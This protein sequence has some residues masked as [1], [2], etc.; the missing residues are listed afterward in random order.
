MPRHPMNERQIHGL[1][2]KIVPGQVQRRRPQQ[3][4]SR[5][6]PAFE[7]RGRATVETRQHLCVGRRHH[8]AIAVDPR[9]GKVTAPGRAKRLEYGMAVLEGA[10]PGCVASCAIHG[11]LERGRKYVHVLTPGGARSDCHEQPAAAFHKPLESPGQ[12]RRHG[13]VVQ[14]HHGCTPEVVV[15][16]GIL[17]AGDGL[18]ARRITDRERAVQIQRSAAGAATID[19]DDANR[20]NGRHDEMK[21]VVGGKG[22]IA[23]SHAAAHE[24]SRHGHR[25]ERHRRRAVRLDVEWFAL[26]RA[27]AEFK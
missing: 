18:E 15:G 26:N 14:Q 4:A 3:H 12:R 6:D 8:R 9:R 11:R 10:N 2:R 7:K 1:Q 19:D 23:G 20:L 22:I 5:A 27:S 21:Y 17:V 25:I 24:R 13:D 16:E